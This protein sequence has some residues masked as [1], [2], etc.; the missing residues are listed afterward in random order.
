NISDIADQFVDAGALR[1]VTSTEDI[2]SAFAGLL[3]NPADWTR[4]SAAALE[5]MKQNRGALEKV[6]KS[7]LSN[8]NSDK[9]S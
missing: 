2:R 1:T 8:L 6:M 4:M 9:I 7:I 3:G 5:V